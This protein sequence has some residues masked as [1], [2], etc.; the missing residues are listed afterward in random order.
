MDPHDRR[1]KRHHR[2]AGERRRPCRHRRDP[3]LGTATRAMLAAFC[4]GAPEP[5]TRACAI[6]GRRDASKL[7]RGLVLWFPGPASFTGEDMAEL[8]VH[9]SRAVIGAV[10]D[11]VLVAS[12][13]RDSPNPASSRAAPSRTASSI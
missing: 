5:A 2:C 8:H 12:P 6:S 3:H 10:I 11:A 7:D 13:A 9:G 1:H 4:G